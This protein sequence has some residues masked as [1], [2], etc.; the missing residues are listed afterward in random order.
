MDASLAANWHRVSLAFSVFDKE[1]VRP[2]VNEYRPI[3]SPAEFGAILT[4]ALRFSDQYTWLYTQWQD[5]WGDDM[6]ERLQPYIEAI[7]AARRDV[8][9]KP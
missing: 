4:K 1:R 9:M 7:E 5:W 8:G 2:G 6:D 3:E